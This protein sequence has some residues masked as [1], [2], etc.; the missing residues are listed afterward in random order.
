M[1]LSSL[2][3]FVRVSCSRSLLTLYLAIYQVLGAAQA[4]FFPCCV[5]Y[6][7]FWFPPSQLTLRLAIFGS[8]AYFA[9][10]IGGFIAFA[11]S[12]ADGRLPGWRWLF[13]IGDLLSTSA[14]G[15]LLTAI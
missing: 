1:G 10:V 5:Y 3:G 8:S 7:T 6:L 9:G 15:Y 12:F 13:I 14:C 4:G 11:A 2:V